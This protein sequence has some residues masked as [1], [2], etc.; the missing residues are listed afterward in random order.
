MAVAAAEDES[1]AG[2]VSLSSPVFFHIGPIPISE[3]IFS[4]WVVMAI[5]VIL[6]LVA[7][8][9]LKL[10][11]R[12]FQNLVEL[13]IETLVGLI[14]Q[15]AGPTGRSFAPVV[16]TLFLFILTANWMGTF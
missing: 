6:S 11:P 13:L 15:V 12:G 16:M 7:T 10:V 4:A 9:S 5:L 3:H 14:D 8:R 2:S 1:S